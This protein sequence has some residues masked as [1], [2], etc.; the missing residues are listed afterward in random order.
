VVA[1]NAP[2]SI[3]LAAEYGQGWITT[4]APSED[5]ESWWGAVAD[6]AA[7]FGEALDARSRAQDSVARYL[8][9]DAAPVFS[10][11]SLDAFTDAVGRAAALGFTDVITHWPRPDS[12]YAGDEAILDELPAVMQAHRSG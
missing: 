6:R 2:R 11:S 10:L 3:A 9:L 8:L 1:A 12:W 5:L 4:G 7:L